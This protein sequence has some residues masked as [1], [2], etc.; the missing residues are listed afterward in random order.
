MLQALQ[1]LLTREEAIL[2][3]RGDVGDK[4]LW[5]QTEVWHAFSPAIGPV[6][7]EV[8]AEQRRDA[9][10]EMSRLSDGVVLLDVA[11]VFP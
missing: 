7:R 6:N 1:G 3:R 11:E 8:A 4:A 9:S 10:G 5:R 2:R